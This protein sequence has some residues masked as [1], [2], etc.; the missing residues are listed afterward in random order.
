MSAAMAVRAALSALILLLLL[1][2]M[3]ALVFVEIPEANRDLF[4]TFLGAVLSVGL[5][6]VVSYWLGSSQS[7]AGKD[8]T[9]RSLTKEG[10]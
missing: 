1:L 8:Q 7:S 5:G 10:D 2:A 3:A 4:N 6:N 9:I